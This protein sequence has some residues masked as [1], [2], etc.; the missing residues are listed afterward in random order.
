[1]LLC[2]N[3]IFLIMSF[4]NLKLI[5]LIISITVLISMYALLSNFSNVNESDVHRSEAVII[6]ARDFTFSVDS[7]TVRKGTTLIFILINEGRYPHNLVLKNRD[8]LVELVQLV[9]PGNK[10]ESA[11]KFTRE[12]V[13]DFL[14]TVAYPAPVPHYELG[15]KGVIIVR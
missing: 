1:M 9:M 4:G 8:N 3:A 2:M 14:C 5:L 13:Y 11:F 10:T 6:V 7:L 15:M 12:G